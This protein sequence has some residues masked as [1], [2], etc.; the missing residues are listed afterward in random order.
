MTQLSMR[1]VILQDLWVHLAGLI[2]IAIGVAAWYFANG[3]KSDPSSL[4]LMLIVGGFAGMGLKLMNGT[5]AVLRQ[6]ALDASFAASRAAQ[7]AAA[8]AA[9]SP[10][11]TAQVT[12][13]PV[14]VVPV[15]PAVG[16]QG[17]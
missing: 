16:A 6:A 14:Q 5:T 2:A 17:A 12:Q 15:P 11:S 7:A 4:Q 13:L 10:A 3:M 8:A 9:A 1:D